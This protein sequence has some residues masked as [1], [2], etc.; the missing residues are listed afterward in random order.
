[1]PDPRSCNL[2]GAFIISAH[3]RLMQDVS[4]ELSMAGQA[5]AALVTVKHNRGRS[6]DFLSGALLL[7]HSGCVRLVDKLS[8]AGLIER[9]QGAD[10]RV[11][12]LFLT[13]AGEQRVDQIL[14]ARRQCLQSLLA[15]LDA[16]QERQLTVL[17]EAM[18]A[19]LTTSKQQSD[20]MCRL[21]EES[22]CPQPLCPITRA[23]PAPASAG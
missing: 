21:C 11:V 15:P 23:I 9:R 6:V 17:L 4:A 16:E 2:L 10:K 3:D 8:G 14:C 5:A 22:V 19:N 12:S 20:V 18:L 7:S 13:P 1:M